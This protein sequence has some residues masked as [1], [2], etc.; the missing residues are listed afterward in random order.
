MVMLKRYLLPVL[1]GFVSLAFIPVLDGHAADET[2]ETTVAIIDLERIRQESKAGQ[3]IEGQIGT[4][5]SKLAEEVNRVEGEL[6]E[7]QRSLKDQEVLLTQEAYE[8]QRQKIEQDSV[9]YQNEYQNRRRN[10]DTAYLRAMERLHAGVLEILGKLIFQRGIDVV[11]DRRQYLVANS[12]LD[13]TEDVL[14]ELNKS[15]SEIPISLSS[16]S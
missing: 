10:L 5:R 8:K 13:I 9:A 4:Y 7:R 1:V 11:L 16:E 14:T 6:R 2:M 15:L 3:S 12:T